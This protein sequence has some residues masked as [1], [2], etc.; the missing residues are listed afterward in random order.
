MVIS[1]CFYVQLLNP[2]MYYYII[3]TYFYRH[4]EPH[5]FTFVAQLIISIVASCD[6]D[7]ITLGKSM[8]QSDRE[9]LIKS[10]HT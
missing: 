2:Y 1:S 7:T 10:M 4:V 8:D 6:L 3:Q 9:Y 5:I